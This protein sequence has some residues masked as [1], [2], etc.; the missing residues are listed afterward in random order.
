MCRGV[1]VGGADAIKRGRQDPFSA[2][3][4]YVFVFECVLKFQGLL[5]D[6]YGKVGMYFRDRQGRQTG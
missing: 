6:L 3:C 1:F 4:T 2:L 5:L